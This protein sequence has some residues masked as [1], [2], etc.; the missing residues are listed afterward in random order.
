VSSKHKPA[1]SL[2]DIVEN[3]ERIARHIADMDRDA[4]ARN[5]LTRDGVERCLERICEAAHRLGERAPQ[6]VPDQNW[7]DIRGMGN[8]LRHAY[9]QVTLEFIWTAAHDEVPDLAS[10]V[11]VALEK[12]CL[13]DD[14]GD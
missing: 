9:D 2:A 3:A 5:E 14:E 7:R 4:F 6:L 12:L 13:E 1:D 10:A 11:R 8:R